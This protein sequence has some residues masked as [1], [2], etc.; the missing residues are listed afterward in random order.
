MKHI[1]HEKKRALSLLLVLVMLAFTCNTP[2]YAA[3]TQNSV[4]PYTEDEL[5]QIKSIEQEIVNALE[6]EQT[7]VKLT[8]YTISTERL[9]EGKALEYFSDRHPQY[10]GIGLLYTFQSALDRTITGVDIIWGKDTKK[11]RDAIKAAT[12]ELVAS[13]NSSKK[14]LTDYEKAYIAYEWLV[15]N[16][17]YDKKCN[18]SLTIEENKKILDPDDYNA[19]GALVKKIAVCSGY[20]DAYRYIV[21]CR[22]GIPCDT[23]INDTHAWNMVKIGDHYYHVDATWGDTKDYSSSFV[24]SD[25]STGNSHMKFFL[26]SDK[27]VKQ[28]AAHRFWVSCE[29]ESHKADTT[30]SER[31][32]VWESFY[33]MQSPFVYFDGCFYF[34]DYCT[35]YRVD[36]L[37][38]YTDGKA[39]VV[40]EMGTKAAG[41]VGTEAGLVNIIDYHHCLYFNGFHKIFRY[42]PTEVTEE[43]RAFT[44]SGSNNLAKDITMDVAP[45]DAL[46][47][48][49]KES[50]QHVITDFQIAENA[51]KKDYNVTFNISGDT[52]YEAQYP[53]Q[54]LS[55]RLSADSITITGEPT[56]G[57]TVNAGCNLLAPYPFKTVTPYYHWYRGDELISMNDTGDYTITGDDIGKTLSVTVVC[58]NLFGSVTKEVFAI[59]KQKPAKP[60]DAD[61][62]KLS[63]SKDAALKTIELPEGYTWKEPDTILDKMGTKTYPALYCPDSEKYDPLEL[64]LTVTVTKC[65]H[66]WNSGK[67]TK[68]ATCLEEGVK[69]YTCSKCKAIKTEAIA[70]TDHKWG[71]GKVTTAATC[72]KDGVKTFTCSICKET[73]TQVIP[74]TNKHTYSTTGTVTKAPTAT[75]KG[76]F[77]LTCKNCTQTKTESLSLGTIYNLKT[78]ALLPKGRLTVYN[79]A[80]DKSSSI[81]FIENGDTVYIVDNRCTDQY[82]AI[83]QKNMIGYVYKTNVK[84]GAATTTQKTQKTTQAPKKQSKKDNGTSL[85]KGTTKTVSGITYKV[86]ATGSTKTVEVT[87]VSSAMTSVTIPATVKVNNVTYTVTSIAAKAYKGNKNLKKIVIGKNVSKIGK[88]AFLNCKN[89]KTI[90]IKSTKLTSVGAKAIKGIHKKAKITCPAKKKA[91]YKKLFKAKTGFK[92]SMTI[93]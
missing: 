79:E 40:Q 59:P 81:S 92:K 47:V 51:E 55:A 64:D 4:K 87:K 33:R 72:G 60:A 29:L 66:T 88:E 84:K 5:R 65:T 2:V 73:K 26:M 90:T 18:S 36:D 86:T 13:I 53:G 49:Q 75:D 28:L 91:A 23:V 52:S 48:L 56:V 20:T 37:L 76:I 17:T 71:S 35:L 78:T 67:V 7:K 62:P 8:G 30:I 74:K 11:K 39:E 16:C 83:I 27:Q 1:K 34:A 12:D 22:L 15:R 44:K 45:M 50:S 80:T 38:N 68:K 54:S 42:N 69:T 77:T 63:G 14:K 58:D 89:L 85:K 41:N 9:A 93:K 57:T 46:M 82:T 19:Y 24:S 31:N 61:L 32:P 43:Q 10:M 70:K 25:N 21:E 3:T 6:K